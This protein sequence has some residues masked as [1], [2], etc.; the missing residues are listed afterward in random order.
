MSSSDRKG[1]I[2]TLAVFRSSDGA[3]VTMDSVTD[4]NEAGAEAVGRWK[5]A[6]TA[7]VEQ[8]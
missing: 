4:V 3:L 6:T 5:A 1:G 2:P 7:M 8:K